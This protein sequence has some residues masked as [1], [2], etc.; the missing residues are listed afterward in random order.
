MD[1]K[2]GDC[3]EPDPQASTP[4]PPQTSREKGWFAQVCAWLELGRPM[5]KMPH[6]GMRIVKTGLVVFFTLLIYSLWNRPDSGAFL[7][8]AAG[9]VSMQ[10]TMGYS[11]RIGI[12]RLLATAIGGVLGVIC[13]WLISA[14]GIRDM[15]VLYA[16]ALALSTILCIIICV[17]LN[18][19]EGSVLSIVVCL[20]ILINM[21]P[22]DSYVYALNRAIDTGIGIVLSVILNLAIRRPPMRKQDKMDKRLGFHGV[23]RVRIREKDKKNLDKARSLAFQH[24]RQRRMKNSKNQKKTQRKSS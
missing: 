6:I 17:W 13:V 4:E 19:R 3:T 11:L 14:L 23:R 5:R 7:A 18:L 24:D 16:L 22:S 10:D 21:E 9:I 15:A 1:I 8:V 2:K 12:V 20:A